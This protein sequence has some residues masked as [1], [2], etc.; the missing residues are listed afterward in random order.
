MI[1]S[2]KL[3]ISHV[4]DEEADIIHST[5]IGR[6]SLGRVS[7]LVSAWCSRRLGCG[8]LYLSDL[9][10][11]IQALLEFASP[12]EG[13]NL[14][15]QIELGTSDGLLLVATRFECNLQFSPDSIERDLTQYWLNS[16]D[17]KLLK[18]VLLSHDRVEV[19]YL[20]KLNLIEWRVCRGL[21]GVET[22]HDSSFL[23]LVDESDAVDA[24]TDRYVDLGDLP[25]EEWVSDVY[26]NKNEKTKSGDVRIEGGETSQNQSEWA[27]VVSEKESDEIDEVVINAVK[28]GSYDQDDEITYRYADS[29]QESIFER[30]ARY[31][32]E[33]VTN[34]LSEQ[35]GLKENLKTLLLEMKQRDL[36][37][38]REV[39]G[40]QRK[41]DELDTLLKRKELVIQKVQEQVQLLQNRISGDRK[42]KEDGDKSSQFRLKAMEMFEALKKVKNEKTALEKRMAEMK[43]GREDGSQ[44]TGIGSSEVAAQK[45]I[46]ELNKKYERTVRALEAEKAKIKVLNERAMSAE[47]EAQS[48]APLVKDLETKVEH[49]LK[50]NQQHKKEME[51]MKLKHVQAEAEKNRIKN[52]LVKAQAQIQ[53]L[54]KRQAA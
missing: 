15:G 49:A 31:S 18:K 35:V 36:R 53:T 39:L 29:E 33:V 40:S 42:Q 46:E 4:L 11:L 23:I 47:K 50:V 16:D 54:M 51:T 25:Y 6:N 12:R 38:K 44:G 19:R 22:S 17:A 34:L 30:S 2:P 48:T 7:D 5:I 28:D 26:R 9:R 10:I 27:R 32:N 41:L 52:D 1:S 3:G 43:S 37:N 13:K 21:E 14:L 24:A 45:Q 8:T 20:T